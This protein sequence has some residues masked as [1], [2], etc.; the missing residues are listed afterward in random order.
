V[1]LPREQ[2]SHEVDVLAFA[3]NMTVVGH[4]QRRI[5]ASVRTREMTMAGLYRNGGRVALFATRAVAA[6]D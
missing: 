5:L 1:L 4:M 2:T 6:L 3:S